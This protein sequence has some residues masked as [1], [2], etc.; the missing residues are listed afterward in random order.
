MTDAKNIDEAWAELLQFQGAEKEALSHRHELEREAFYRENKRHF[1]EQA[2]GRTGAA[3]AV[4][5]PRP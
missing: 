5:A 2:D 1:D 4:P 3:R